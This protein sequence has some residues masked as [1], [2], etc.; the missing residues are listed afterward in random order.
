MGRAAAG[1]PSGVAHASADAPRPPSDARLL[2]DELLLLLLLELLADDEREAE[3]EQNVLLS[4]RNASCWRLDEL[5][6]TTGAD[7][8]ASPRARAASS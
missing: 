3:A 4:W 1:L 7:E 5:A 2:A 8:E 6:T